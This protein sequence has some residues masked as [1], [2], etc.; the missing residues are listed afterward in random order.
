MEMKM[1]KNLNGLTSEE[2]LRSREKYGDNSLEREK[3]KGFFILECSLQ[4]N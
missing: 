2:A 4:L 1:I 3:K